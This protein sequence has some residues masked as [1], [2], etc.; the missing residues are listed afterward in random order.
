MAINYFC[1]VI[2]LFLVLGNL[3][4]ANSR[5]KRQIMVKTTSIHK[6]DIG[7]V[8]AFLLIC[9]LVF[10]A[11]TDRDNPDYNSYRTSYVMHTVNTVDKGFEYLRNIGWSLGWSFELFHAVIYGF[12]Y[13]VTWVALCRFGINKNFALGLYALFPFAYDAIQIRWFCACSVVL[14]SLSFFMEER[15]SSIVKYVIGVLIASTLH[16]LSIVY[17]LFLLVK[18]EDSAKSK[19]T[20]LRVVFGLS[21]LVIIVSTVNPSFRQ[22]LIYYFSLNTSQQK[23]NYYNRGVNWRNVI[24]L[25]AQELFFYFSAKTNY[26][27]SKSLDGAEHHEYRIISNLIYGC[28]LAICCTLPL[29]LISQ[30]FHRIYRNMLI[31]NYGLPGLLIGN[32]TKDNR[33]MLCMLLFLLGFFSNLLWNYYQDSLNVL[34]VFFN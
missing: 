12:F 27:I 3:F 29:L 1:V 13:L 20:I 19:Q 21:F 34:L 32:E 30:N 24:F 6:I 9:F 22:L 17:L 11:I 31:L 10:L 23:F 4:Y 8:L 2:Y 14:F 16:S 33:K 26:S 25:I 5:N 18:I 15:K 28:N 7:T